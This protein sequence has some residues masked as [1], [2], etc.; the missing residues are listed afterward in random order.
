MPGIILGPGNT[1]GTEIELNKTKHQCCIHG[2]S[3]SNRH[4]SLVNWVLHTPPPH[5][6]QLD[7]FPYT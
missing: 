2:A 3:H 1:T 7:I 5:L 6:T 4:Q